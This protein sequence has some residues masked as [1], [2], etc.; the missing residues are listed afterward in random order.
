MMQQGRFH[1]HKGPMTKLKD[2][3]LNLI[4]SPED[5]AKMEMY[6]EYIGVCKYCFDPRTTAWDAPRVHHYHKR[7]DSFESLRRRVSRDRLLH[8][9]SLERVDKESRYYASDSSRRRREDRHSG[10]GLASAGLAA[11]GTGIAANAI[12]SD[13]KNFDDTYSVKSGHRESSAVRRRSRSS[14]R[15]KRRRSQYGTIRADHNEFV[16]VRRKDGTV[17]Q[18][19]VAKS[20]SRS[21]DRKASGIGIG[22]IAAAAALGAAGVA[23]SS[24]R[25]SRSSSREHRRRSTRVSP[26]RSEHA[27]HDRNDKRQSEDEG[28]GGIFGNFFSPSRTQRRN[29]RE[30]QKKHGGFFTFSNGSSS[31]S[32]SELA[33]G[34]SFVSRNGSKTSLSRRSSGRSS[35]GRPQRKTSDQH[36]AATLAGIGATAAALGAA[37][38]GHRISKRA[39]R[40]ELGARRQVRQQVVGDHR[41][42]S[43]GSFEDEEWE[44]ELPSDHASSV[45]GLA[46]GDYGDRRLSNRQSLE[47]VASQS[48]A[49]G[50]GAWGWRWGGKDR[51]R[52]PGRSISA[53]TPY[54]HNQFGSSIGPTGAGV[55]AGADSV[56]DPSRPVQSDQPIYLDDTGR[57]LPSVDARSSTSGASSQPLQYVEPRPLSEAGTSN[58][59]YVPG[60]FDT[61]SRVMSMPGAFEPDDAPIYRPGPSVVQHPQPMSPARPAFTQPD[62][63]RGYTAT[64]GTFDDRPNPRRTQSSPVQSSWGQDAALIGAGVLGAGA[65]IA[66]SAMSSGRK[67]K[68]SPSNV[69]FGLTEEQQR[70]ESRSIRRE[71]KR[72]DDERRRSDRTRAL[73]DEAERAAKES[74]Q[75]E[76]LRAREAEIQ[77][78]AQAQLDSQLEQERKE[79]EEAR[80]RAE[81][82]AREDR[83]R[84][85]E[86][87]R[88]QKEAADRQAAAVEANAEFERQR[89]AR[90][91]AER[92]RAEAERQ[93]REREEAFQR[94]QYQLAED[95]RREDEQRRLWE[96]ERYAREYQE[97]AKKKS[98]RDS[99]EPASGRGHDN[100]DAR[101]ESSYNWGAVAAGA[102]A[103]AGV[104]AILAEREEKKSRR[105]S[106]TTDSTTDTPIS[107]RPPRTSVD[108]TADVHAEDRRA[109]DQAELDRRVRE[110]YGHASRGSVELKDGYAAAEIAP[111]SDVQGEPILD[112]DL[113]NPDFFMR[114]QH[115]PAD[116]ARHEDL[117]RRAADKVVAPSPPASS[118]DMRPKD[119]YANFFADELKDVLAKKPGEKERSIQPDSD[120]HV[121]HVEDDNLQRTFT[122]RDDLGGKSKQA[123][124]GVPRLNVIAPTPPPSS[125]T[126]ST[127]GS[128]SGSPLTKTVDAAAERDESPESSKDSGKSDR[129]RSI[130]WG[131]DKTHIY[132][133][134]TPESYQERDRDSYITSPDL[135]GVGEGVTAAAVATGMGAALHGIV[136]EDG[137]QKTTYHDDAFF[138]APSKKTKKE[139]KKSK[140][141]SASH[142]DDADS[143]FLD[144]ISSKDQRATSQ[145]VPPERGRELPYRG[146]ES[147]RTRKDNE[148]EYEH[149]EGVEEVR[150]NPE[151]TSPGVMAHPLY[152]QP[153]FDS[154]SDFSSFRAIES[155]GTEGAPP[156]RGFVEGETEE[157]TPLEERLPHVPGGFVND[158]PAHRP[159]IEMTNTNDSFG[160][161]GD[162]SKDY[163]PED[164]AWQPPLSKKDKKK[165]DK[166]AK[167]AGNVALDNSEPSTSLNEIENVPEEQTWEHPE[168]AAERKKREKEAKRTGSS[169]PF[170]TEPTPPVRE[171]EESAWEPPLS[172]KE[173][174][175]REKE[176]KR[177]S[178]TFSSDLVT[179]VGE[180]KPDVDAWEPPLSAKER[181]KRE[182][183]AKKAGI[184]P[185]YSE[186]ATPIVESPKVE[187]NEPDEYFPSLSKTDKQKK[188]KPFD[189]DLERMA[190]VVS[191]VSMPSWSGDTVVSDITVKPPSPE[192]SKSEQRMSEK[193]AKK[194]VS[195]LA[196]VT[197]TI[198]ATGG[199]AAAASALH[200]STEESTSGS[201]KKDKKKKKKKSKLGE[202]T[203][204]DPRD[205]P[206]S[207][208]GG[209]E[210]P[211]HSPS[212]DE[213]RRESQNDVAAHALNA[214][215]RNGDMS[216]SVHAAE[217]TAVPEAEPWNE[218]S[219][220][221]SAKKGKKKS[222]RSSVAFDNIPQVSSPLRSEVAWDDYVGT[223]NGTNGD[224]E[225]DSEAARSD[226]I[227]VIE[228]KTSDEGKSSRKSSKDGY[229][230]AG[231]RISESPR[232]ISPEDS[233]SVTSSADI[234]RESRRKSRRDEARRGAENYDQPEYAYETQS[235]TASEPADEEGRKKHKRRSRHEDDDTMSVS[236]GRR[237]SRQADDDD[238]T[239]SVASSRSR[240]EKEESPSVKKE[241]KGIF[242]SLFSRKSSDALPLSKESPRDGKKDDDDDEERRRRKKKH[243]DSEYGDDDD[244]TRSVKSES[245]RRR[246]RS[247]DAKEEEDSRERRRRSTHDDDGKHSESGSRHHRRRRTNEDGESLARHE[248][249]ESRSD[250]SERPKH[251][252]RRTDEDKYD[253]RD[254]SFLGSRVEEL[255]PLPVSR[256]GSPSAAVERMEGRPLEAGFGTGLVSAAAVGVA[257]GVAANVLSR[258]KKRKSPKKSPSKSPNE[259]GHENVS[260]QF[261]NENEDEDEAR[262]IGPTKSS[263]FHEPL[264]S[265]AAHSF[266]LPPVVEAFEVNRAVEP[267]EDLPHSP[268]PV[269]EKPPRPVSI[270]RPGSSTTIPL[271][272]PGHAPITFGVQE[273]TKSFSSPTMATQSGSALASPATPI[274]GKGRHRRSL[275]SELT[276]G[277]MPL[278]LVERSR[279]TPKVEDTLP[280]LPSSKPSSRASSAHG[281]DEYESAREE[282]SAASSPQRSRSRSLTLDTI[283][284]NSYRGDGDILD[285][286]QTTPKASEWPQTAIPWSLPTSVGEKKERQVPQ[287]YTWEDFARDEKM[288]EQQ[289]GG[290]S[291]V[292]RDRAGLAGDLRSRSKSP[293]KAKALA[294]AAMLGTAAVYTARRVKDRSPERPNEPLLHGPLPS[295]AAHSYPLPYVPAPEPAEQEHALHNAES[296][297]Q[298]E[299]KAP[300]S[301]S[302][303]KKSK[304]KSK[305]GKIQ[306][307]GVNKAS[308]EA[309]LPLTQLE[310]D[311]GAQA[312]DQNI[313]TGQA[314]SESHPENV[315]GS[316]DD[317]SVHLSSMASHT[318]ALLPLLDLTEPSPPKESVAEIL[319]EKPTQAAEIGYLA[320]A[321]AHSMPV[322]TPPETIGDVPRDDD[323][324]PS[325]ACKLL[326]VEADSHS[327]A[328]EQL[329]VQVEPVAPVEVEPIPQL[330]RKQSKK[331]KKKDKKKAKTSSTFED[332]QRA[333]DGVTI[334]EKPF[335]REASID[336]D[337]EVSASA[338]HIDFGLS[339]FAAV[340]GAAA[341][342]WSISQADAFRDSM[343]NVEKSAPAISLDTID[344]PAGMVGDAQSLDASHVASTAVDEEPVSA[345]TISKKE[346]K[347]KK[348]S[349]QSSTLLDDQG[350]SEKLSSE[351]VAAQPIEEAAESIESLHDH[352]REAPVVEPDIQDW[353]PSSFSQKKGKKDRKKRLSVLSEPEVEMP[354]ADASEQQGPF[355]DLPRGTDDAEQT[356]A[357]EPADNASLPASMDAV[358]RQ[359]SAPTLGPETV[360]DS[361]A[362]ISTKK[363]RKDRKKKGISW[364]DDTVPAPES[365]ISVMPL[366]NDLELT[367]NIKGI[368]SPASPDLTEPISEQ[369]ATVEVAPQNLAAATVAESTPADDVA[370]AVPKKQSKRD[371][372][373]SK[374]FSWDEPEDSR[375]F[376]VHD[377]TE[378]TP[379]E[380]VIASQ[381]EGASSFIEP[382]PAPAMEHENDG[383]FVQMEQA[384]PQQ[385]EESSTSAVLKKQTKKDKK[386]KKQANS[387]A[388]RPS[389][390]PPPTV[391]DE[392]DKPR[393][394]H[395]TEDS[396]DKETA[397]MTATAATAAAASLIPAAIAHDRDPS[398]S[399]TIL[400]DEDEVKPDADD[401]WTGPESSESS[402][403]ANKD[404]EEQVLDQSE[405]ATSTSP[406]EPID[407]PAGSETM[408]ADHDAL[409]ATQ[410]IVVGEETP[411]VHDVV[412][413]G[414]DMEQPQASDVLA[415]D[416]DMEQPHAMPITPKTAEKDK[417]EQRELDSSE[418]QTSNL[419]PTVND[420]SGSPERM[421]ADH[422]TLPENEPAIVRDET[423]S[424]REK[425]PDVDVEKPQADGAFEMPSTSKKAKKAK[426][427]K[428]MKQA[429]DGNEWQPAIPESRPDDHSPRIEAVPAERTASLVNGPAEA[430]DEKP[431]PSRKQSK[432]DKRKQK[433]QS[434]QV[435]SELEV[436]RDTPAADVATLTVA[437]EP[438]NESSPDVDRALTEEVSPPVDTPDNSFH[439]AEDFF[440]ESAVAEPW[441]DAE[442]TA[443]QTDNP[444]TIATEELSPQPHS[445][446]EAVADIEQGHEQLQKEIN[447]VAEDFGQAR[448]EKMQDSP[449]DPVQDNNLVDDVFG[450]VSDTG[451][452][453]PSQSNEM[454]DREEVMAD[455]GM[456]FEPERASEDMDAF[457]EPSP[458]DAAEWSLT[459]SK[460]TGKKG[461]KGRKSISKGLIKSESNPSSSANVTER[462]V[463][464]SAVPDL[465]PSESAPAIDTVS[466]NEMSDKPPS[467]ESKD[468]QDQSGLPLVEAEPT[469][470]LPEGA[471][472]PA[473]GLSTSP[474]TD[475]VEFRVDSDR[476][477]SDLVHESPQGKI[478]TH[479]SQSEETKEQP[480]ADV[481]E[482]FS[483]APSSKKKKK[484]KN[485]KQG[486]QSTLEPKSAPDAL[487]EEGIMQ[488]TA[489]GL[490]VPLGLTADPDLAGED[491]TNINRDLMRRV[492]APPSSPEEQENFATAPVSKKDKKKGEE[493]Q[494]TWHTNSK[495]N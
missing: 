270:G 238:D 210:S 115:S 307:M 265:V 335:S 170:D 336:R 173:R 15:E 30:R 195:G 107:R 293:S 200:D 360:D 137:N 199:I 190:S 332:E 269:L 129:S 489:G 36:L 46:F 346:K 148:R 59:Q 341:N 394:G 151:A 177:A 431:T 207:M 61:P 464:E 69:R 466:G 93:S 315:Y 220:P 233:R 366:N 283:G 400:A 348:K 288:H 99:R 369:Q 130:S 164:S 176:A 275:S 471:S 211:E 160:T 383:D 246:H 323:D 159:G 135:R 38:A 426:K 217:T 191:G 490:E 287:F 222:K 86:I 23:A 91:D 249:R 116:Q 80:S 302:S 375:H 427:D 50:L 153:F 386:K 494:R 428:R 235:V 318:H 357:A 188:P 56:F 271:R 247:T 76:V 104:G 370:P 209:W 82:R 316:P 486:K 47:S 223:S 443:G 296:P 168:S 142:G 256:P 18:R 230:E 333:Q 54:T 141:I 197:D 311:A 289:G 114:S 255:P 8:K 224:R 457:G 403:R 308:A 6:T 58:Q 454:G 42:G 183:A 252:R 474:G 98:A 169:G 53:E 113:F 310:E 181:K 361:L 14:S 155:P 72:A 473:V 338:P 495:D 24:R 331:D 175:K 415:T 455:R 465:L 339:E 378:N 345:N 420:E 353:A 240:R 291:A 483:W 298:F 384:E 433:A 425:S 132:D 198:L 67:G 41:H 134:Q 376:E 367:E 460:K 51:K 206:S 273:R 380:D 440:D 444:Q 257:A 49:G 202:S 319:P 285:S 167:R 368:S 124:S 250:I 73:K 292:D 90:E 462:G 276:S 165:R 43:P 412:P 408:A 388:A 242:G 40:P 243:R 399:E 117:A 10:M 482:E 297:R 365:E 330:T 258:E 374:L 140:K 201:T 143:T 277:I 122:L 436:E 451:E 9:G 204:D 263:G 423:T 284:A 81:Q 430:D 481:E 253:S 476:G 301:V 327:P 1:E 387:W 429:L 106:A 48:S 215:D 94:Q 187:D 295:V 226:P 85:W 304:K 299:E 237:R 21:R 409:P 105:Q 280:S 138:T 225:A 475:E 452:L 231:Q 63:D 109:A 92:R 405:P 39:S 267:E 321:A 78:R 373:K 453:N 131:E 27:R 184:D 492:E 203:Y 29:S 251:H 172:A 32:N 352:H 461:K 60:A 322:Y 171:P 13:R 101:Q 174:K 44:D 219:E 84:Q 414:A 182:K 239:R 196:D 290:H 472:A 244:D 156:V 62:A 149:E 241:K 344:A 7:S 100:E 189:H 120:V 57:P 326:P 126:E 417:P 75:E 87:E 186:A 185:S 381:D 300:E 139:K 216:E 469:L 125:K 17:E 19:R 279:P 236:S 179:A 128:V 229:D 351:R 214:S 194:S 20:R 404:G 70:K 418:P 485:S 337:V 349:K 324:R 422:G 213:A 178:S 212:V 303:S 127:K 371:K 205:A 449:A 16:T 435:E 248:S 79:A 438:A 278:Y 306:Q 363:S 180:R 334:A 343:Q 401:P 434:R 458:R 162:T 268:A 421:P 112:D 467:E 119:S 364:V 286:Q 313:K 325:T 410:P 362:T 274:F 478:E 111:G 272:L 147:S 491:P 493:G 372:K 102:A 456:E 89:Q 446:A 389:E 480:T 392:N 208:P 45:D 294:A 413:I 133:V 488:Q 218:W 406:P 31:S 329:S 479:N 55:A 192:P 484:S 487:R 382:S 83:E 152:Q 396:T 397:F 234:D 342:A 468:F 232:D 144:D 33:F 398:A 245:H 34:G 450:I 193:E 110:Q 157:P 441:H 11:V 328:L 37:K 419:P 439:D 266:S 4:S 97:S 121:H 314:Q 411:P 317:E 52:R 96:A 402:K 66:G 26:R 350:S 161:S 407:K 477:D 385:E 108:W 35:R 262:R 437:N 281:S 393:D 150:R 228:R 123:P 163:G 356:P 68:D 354:P 154:V 312:A 22:S 445:P 260:G 136:A 416:A 25:R 395:S 227:T 64:A 320:S 95:A 3:L 264:P 340:A 74:R 391:T 379:M 259:I 5:V 377:A 88:L 2:G 282:L 77:A 459:S 71:D 166:E 424:T 463:P 65:I 448:D 158:E 447:S 442:E 254:Q 359:A 358:D 470:E 146:N 145:D 221:A 103:A 305:K 432:K 28:G 355:D 347:K 118:P 261:Q 390:S 309:A 12:F